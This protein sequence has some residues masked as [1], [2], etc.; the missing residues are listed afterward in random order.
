MCP[1]LTFSLLME[2]KKIKL[3]YI[4]FLFGVLGLFGIWGAFFASGEDIPVVRS[5]LFLAG[6]SS[7]TSV[8]AILGRKLWL[9]WTLASMYLF[10]VAGIVGVLLVTGRQSL[11]MFGFV[12][13]SPLIWWISW[14]GLRRAVFGDA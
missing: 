1:K 6:A 5:A 12:A 3:Y 8:V 4:T 13:L 7:L 11:V 14:R 2:I 9:K 10:L